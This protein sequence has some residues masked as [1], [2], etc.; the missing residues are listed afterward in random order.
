[1]NSIAQYVQWGGIAS[2]AIVGVCLVLS[3]VLQSRP[4]RARPVVLLLVAAVQVLAGVALIMLTNVLLT[5]AWM[6]GMAVIGLVA[7]WFGG[8]TT[9]VGFRNGV[10]AAKVS[11]VAA[12]VTAIVYTGALAAL[13][14][15]SVSYFAVAAQLVV[16][17]AA[18]TAGSAVSSVVRI[19]RAR[20]KARAKEAEAAGADVPA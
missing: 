7:G 13:F 20:P 3:A 10:R 1:M 18:L 9:K 4:R 14:F 11:P 19:V 12:W 15:A 16:L 5:P 6:I 8:L 2:I 17:A